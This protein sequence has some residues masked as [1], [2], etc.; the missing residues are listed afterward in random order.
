MARLILFGGKGG[1]GKT[2]CASATAI[3]LADSGFRTLLVSSDPAHSTSDSLGVQLEN[4][5]T[6]VEEVKNL[7][8]MELDPEG[9]M[10]DLLPKLSSAL[11]GGLGAKMEMFMAPQ[12]KQEIADEMSNIEAADMLL[13]GLDEALA[14]DRLLKH[15]NDPRFDVIIFDTAPTGH[16]LRFLSLPELL[17]GWSGRIA[18]I[19]R[20]SGGIKS[21]IFGRKQ[22]AAIQ[23]ELDRFNERVTETRKILTDETK[24]GFVLVTIPEKMAVAESRRAVKTLGEFNIGVEGVVINRVTPDF[25]HPFIQ[26]RR[27]VEQMHIVDLVETFGGL[28]VGQI[29]LSDSDIYGF[30][31]LREIGQTLH[32]E[33]LHANN[34]SGEIYLGQQIP[35]RIIIE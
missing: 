35:L 3:W 17:E 1:V 16:T 9:Q 15:L 12:A 18:R 7:W 6:E 5:P 4:E 34:G 33:A 13:P 25:D 8:G 27:E 31:L 26:R 10:S 19:S 32:G 11:S 2:T 23:D 21:L 22:E 20:A 14:F 29:P 28:A 30:D 24:T